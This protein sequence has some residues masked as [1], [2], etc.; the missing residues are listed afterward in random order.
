M[1]YL[2]IAGLFVLGLSFAFGA[3]SA[4]TMSAFD[5]MPGWRVWQSGYSLILL[6]IVGVRLWQVVGQPVVIQPRPGAEEVAVWLGALLIIVGIPGR[7][8]GNY[9]AQVWSSDAAVTTGYAIGALLLFGV[10]I[11]ELV[12]ANNPGTTERAA[13][14]PVRN[15]VLVLAGLGLL[16][17][18]MFIG[19]ALLLLLFLSGMSH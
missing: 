16:I 14:E 4:L 18:G 3:V 2:H 11:F 12:V 8:L 13:A 9:L 10:A 19:G 7:L 1:R 17:V 5:S 6:A 15:G